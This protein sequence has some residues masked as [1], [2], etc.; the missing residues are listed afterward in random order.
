M[1][2]ATQTARPAIEIAPM[3]APAITSTIPVNPW[4][5]SVPSLSADVRAC[6]GD[7][8]MWVGGG[9]TGVD[10][11]AAPLAAVSVGASLAVAEEDAGELGLAGGVD[12]D[13][14]VGKGEPVRPGVGKGVRFRAAVAV[15]A[16]V[17]A[18]VGN[19][20]RAG[21]AVAVGAGREAVGL[22]FSAGTGVR[23]GVSVGGIVG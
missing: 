14:S 10:R 2:I 15:C 13:A 16:V 1:P 19:T 12:E 4:I 23:V 22:A 9:R 21:L 18:V 5:E 20:P 3:T 8:G 7:T 6:W 17:G 11:P